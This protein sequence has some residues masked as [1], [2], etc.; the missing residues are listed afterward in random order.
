[1]KKTSNTHRR[2]RRRRTTIWRRK[3]AR[4][5]G[6]IPFRT[7]PGMY[8]LIR[9]VAGWQLDSLVLC[10]ASPLP[11]RKRDDP[12]TPDTGAAPTSCPAECPSSLLPLTPRQPDGQRSAEPS[13][14]RRPPLRVTSRPRGGGS[15]V[16]GQ[17]L[18]GGGGRRRRQCRRRR[19]L[20][21]CGG[22]GGPGSGAWWTCLPAPERSG[23]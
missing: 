1:M 20:W 2:H 19:V 4:K 18:G 11:K 15:D 23:E 17:V 13:T 6:H 21:W 22:R 7:P 3:T 12:V 5:N 10:L 8:G 9:F 14:V 16:T